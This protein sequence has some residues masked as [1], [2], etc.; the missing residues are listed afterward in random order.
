[1]TLVVVPPLGDPTTDLVAGPGEQV[2]DLNQCFARRAG[3]PAALRALA[4]RLD[5]PGAG[6]GSRSAAQQCLLA[7][8][9]ADVL[10]RPG[11]LTPGLLTPWLRALGAAL[12]AVSA[13]DPGLTAT[14]DDITLRAGSTQSSRDTALAAARSTLFA[15][16]L[17]HPELA[18]AGVVEIVVD[19][20]QQLPAAFQ[21][22]ARLSQRDQVPAVVLSG[23]FV[24][25]HR[26]GLDLVPALR[27]VRLSGQVRSRTV[28]RQYLPAGTPPPVWV[29]GT[30]DLPETGPWAA[31][32][33]ASALDA[34]P[35]P[36]WERCT[37]L[38]VSASGPAGLDGAAGLLDQLAGRIPAAL[39]VIVGVPGE[40]AAGVPSGPD[41]AWWAPWRHRLR[42]A[43]FRPYRRTAGPGEG[44]P[45]DDLARWVPPPSGGGPAPA[46]PPP[47]AVARHDLFPGRVAAALFAADD[48]PPPEG[49]RVDPSVRAVRL[50][51]AS[52]D[53]DGPGDFLVDLR[54]GRLTRVR[55]SLARLARSL[56]QDSAAPAALAALHRAPGGELLTGLTRAGVLRR[57]PAA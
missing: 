10:S 26:V 27:G 44:A 40:P 7:L 45:D 8:A 36:A 30:D 12:R 57:E 15:A 47:W 43:G 48:P 18:G 41:D 42:L 14:L 37:G 56:T 9:A 6:A 52:P 17:E 29:T 24:A 50:N 4:A 1:M 39:E 53:D 20:D 28:S 19:A 3:D 25:R 2:L 51:A 34:V 32:L 5:S 23:R 46:L 49:Y 16:E 38:V 22:V 33:D 21:L 55:P 13:G 54:T 35:R 11:P 31:W